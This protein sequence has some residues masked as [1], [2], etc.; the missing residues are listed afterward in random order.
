M[1][2]FFKLIAIYSFLVFAFKAN[3]VESMT[4]SPIY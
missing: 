3:E 2:S 4:P 1:I